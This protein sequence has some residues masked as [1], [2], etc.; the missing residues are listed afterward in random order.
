MVVSVVATW[1][2]TPRLT[3]LAA[4]LIGTT[5]MLAFGCSRP[6]SDTMSSHNEVSADTDKQQC[7]V[8]IRKPS[9]PPTIDTGTFDEHGK[10]VAVSCA[11]CHATRPANT[12]A[13]LG[14]ALAQFHQ[15]TK[16]NHGNLTCVSCH[17]PTDG[18][19]SL[20]LADGNRVAYPDVM[21]LCAQCHG[22]QFRDYEH[23]AHGGM[24]GYWDRSKGGRV[25]N[26][27]VDCHAAHAPKY[28][29]VMPARG[30]NDRFPT[31]GGHE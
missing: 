2:G 8:I 4:L 20:R 28:P 10:P 11:T 7:P 22:P 18:Y 21:T 3:P 26:N 19:G 13:K 31:G 30:P 17:N 1:F 6:P 23:G 16:G 9:G 5:T 12:D 24:T 14:T 29:T 15:Q 25:R 27:C